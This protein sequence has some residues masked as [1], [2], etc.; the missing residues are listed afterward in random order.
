[1]SGGGGT[2]YYPMPTIQSSS[3]ST[4]ND[5]PAWLTNASVYGVKNATNM[6]KQP[7]QAYQGQMAPGMTAD[8][9][10]AGAL[11]RNN[12][13]VANP[14]YNTAQSAYGRSME[15]I[16]PATLA[17]GLSGIS[18]YMNPFISNVLN[19]ANAAGDDAFGRNLNTLR[20]SALRSGAAYGSR[21]GVQEGVAAAQNAMDRQNFAANILSQGYGQAVS[22]LGS[23]VQAQN[24]IAQQNRANAL[25][26][27]TAMQGLGTAQRASD[28]A[29]AKNLLAYG[30]LDQQTQGAQ[31]TAA[32]NEW[33]RQQNMPLQLQQLYNQTVSMA[34]HS[35]SGTSNTTSVGFA[36]QQQATSSPL[37][38]GLGG[39]M[40]GA[41]AGMMVGGPYGAAIGAVGGGL[42]GAFS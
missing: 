27:G 36:P 9:T 5:I 13:G 38:S 10:A 35:T 26:G 29:D 32:Y 16:N 6:L 34:P 33:L 42:L 25:A 24:A 37:V 1:M 40:S 20:D 17:Q 19:A 22:Q 21:H 8:Q 30:S 4:T 12:M 23:D 18:Q 3:S 2:S 41:Q 11:F 39:A 14:A 31:Q 7:V 28:V 15:A